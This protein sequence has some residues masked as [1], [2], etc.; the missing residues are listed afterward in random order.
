MKEIPLYHINGKTVYGGVDPPSFTEFTD[1]K[2][3]IIPA[4]NP[5][6]HEVVYISG[7]SGAGKSYCS[8]MLA[9]SYN[10]FLPKNK[11]IFFSQEPNDENFDEVPFDLRRV[12]AMVYDEPEIDDFETTDFKDSLTILDD[13]DS[14][15]S[16]KVIKL[17]NTLLSRGR[18]ANVK[19]IMTNHTSLQGSL[20]KLI[21]SS[22]SKVI[23]FKD[24][25]KQKNTRYFLEEYAGISEKMIKKIRDGEGPFNSRWFLFSL[26]SPQYL[27]TEKCIIS[28]DD[29]EK[30]AC[31]KKQKTEKISA[32]EKTDINGEKQQKQQKLKKDGTKRKIN[33][34]IEFVKKIQKE[35]KTTYKQALI[36]IAKEK[37]WKK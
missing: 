37:L 29:L 34:F 24:N 20:T 28:I 16:K 31:E 26:R 14:N 9:D 12:N 21:K 19:I 2:S 5:F 30:L 6:V 3:K 4:F 27:L 33:N 7:N 25:L 10:A 8:R 17:V 35:R 13:I 32:S 23:F 15:A 1:P 36:D 11:V 22:C 18:H